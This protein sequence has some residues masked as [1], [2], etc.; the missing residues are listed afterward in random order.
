MTDEESTM[1]TPKNAKARGIA[2]NSLSVE[3]LSDF[4]AG[5]KSASFNRANVKKIESICNVFLSVKDSAKKKS[6]SLK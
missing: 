1:P 2:R 6:A 3:K 5:V 4:T